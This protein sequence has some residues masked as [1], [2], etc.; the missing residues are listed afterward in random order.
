MVRWVNSAMFFAIIA[1][2]A[3][4][5]RWVFCVSMMT[6]KPSP[7]IH[8]VV[9]RFGTETHLSYLNY[10]ILWTWQAVIYF[11]PVKKRSHLGQ[12]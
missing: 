9:G 3:V 4:K 12:K 6:L 11:N 8:G 1:V 10:R 2:F 5:L 7:S